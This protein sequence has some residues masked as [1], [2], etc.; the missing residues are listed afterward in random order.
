MKLNMHQMKLNMHKIKLKL[1]QIKIGAYWV[2]FGANRHGKIIYVYFYYV[3]NNIY[4]LKTI[5]LAIQFME[6]N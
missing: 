3:D 2:S 1:Y 6:H 5:F 4:Y